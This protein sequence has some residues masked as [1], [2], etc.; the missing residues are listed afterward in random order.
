MPEFT[1]DRLL[2]RAAFIDRP[3]EAWK[4]YREYA[5]T[6]RMEAGALRFMAAAMAAAEAGST[7]SGCRLE[8]GDVADGDRNP[9]VDSAVIFV[10]GAD[11][12]SIIEVRAPL[13]REIAERLVLLW[14]GVKPSV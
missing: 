13:A 9:V 2:A 3:I 12:E 8:L 4:G 10:A 6:L 5:D 14:N 1:R 11:E 7:L